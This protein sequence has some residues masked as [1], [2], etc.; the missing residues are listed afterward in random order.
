MTAY[1]RTGLSKEKMAD[2]ATY[3]DDHFV[4][5]ISRDDSRNGKSHRHS[6]MIEY[7]GK[8][9]PELNL[10]DFRSSEAINLDELYGKV[11]ILNFGLLGFERFNRKYNTLASAHS[12]P[13]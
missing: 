5:G 1:L 4:T 10:R 2:L 8:K 11:V 12:L 3:Y 7:V 9:M 13:P 6:N